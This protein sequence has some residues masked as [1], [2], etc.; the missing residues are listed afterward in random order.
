MLVE[1][2]RNSLKKSVS[3]KKIV[4]QELCSDEPIEDAIGIFKRESSPSPTLS[5]GKISHNYAAIFIYHK[6]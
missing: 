1:K 5:A 4:I 6:E 2:R 3:E